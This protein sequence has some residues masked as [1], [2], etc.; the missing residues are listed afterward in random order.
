MNTQLISATTI[1][2]TE[3]VNAKGENIG[4]I[5]DLMIDWE[6]GTVAYAVLSFGGFLGFGEKLFAIPTEALEFDP[7]DQDTII[8]DIEKEHLENAPGFD[9]DEWPTSADRTF[10]NSIY[11]H[12]G[13]EPYWTKY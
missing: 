1:E 12:Y 7:S 3:V 2:G 6:N 8:L 5:K 4:E 13:Y 10:I 9:K 11:K